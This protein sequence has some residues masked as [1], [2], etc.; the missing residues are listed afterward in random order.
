M[1]REQCAHFERIHDRSHLAVRAAKLAETLYRR[2]EFAEAEHWV[3]VSRSNAATDDQSAQLVLGSVE[4]K[5][6]GRQGASRL[7]RELAEA[8]VRI[9]DAT[10]GLNQIAAVKLA[11]SEVLQMAGLMDEAEQALYEAVALYERKG[12]VVAAASTSALLPLAVPA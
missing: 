6:L 10:D 4:A 2:A 12:N 11:L 5:L 7:A 8:T 3:G 9:A 1:L